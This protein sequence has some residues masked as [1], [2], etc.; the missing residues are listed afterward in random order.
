MNFDFSHKQE[1]EQVVAVVFLKYDYGPARGGLSDKVG[2]HDFKSTT[3]S[4]PDRKW[5]ERLQVKSIS[6]L[7][8]SHNWILTGSQPK[9]KSLM[10]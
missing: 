1:V 9:D 3:V 6:K 2:M 5:L 4:H 8:G 7:S 10:D